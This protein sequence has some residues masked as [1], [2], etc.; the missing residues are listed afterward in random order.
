MSKLS[1]ALLCIVSF[2]SIATAD[3]VSYGF[4]YS[5]NATNFGNPSS[6]G[7]VTLTLETAGTYAGDIYVEVDPATGFDVYNEIGFNGQNLVSGA[8]LYVVG[9]NSGW[10]DPSDPLSSASLDHDGAFEYV[11]NPLKAPA[12]TSLGFY[13]EQEDSNGDVVPFTSVLQLSADNSTGYAFSVDAKE[14]DPVTGFIAAS[15][16]EPSTAGLLVLASAGLLIP[17][18]RRKFV[19]A[20]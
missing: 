15:V 4:S 6:Y 17:F 13:V 14:G 1:A 20:N 18:A 3:T 11:Y 10:S 12:T 16:P 7:T 2:A 5:H 8:Q 9:N 19:R